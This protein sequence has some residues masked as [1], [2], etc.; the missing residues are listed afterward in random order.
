MQRRQLRARQAILGLDIDM[1]H[2]ERVDWQDLT[3]AFT[4][5][6]PDQRAAQ[7]RRALQREQI[8][9]DRELCGLRCEQRFTVQVRRIPR[10][11]GVAFLPI[12]HYIHLFQQR[13]EEY[14]SLLHVVAADIFPRLPPSAGSSRSSS[15]T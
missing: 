11:F 1:A 10:T 5:T 8:C 3:K 4:R 2:Q 14:C 6:R 15:Y 13:P 12:F 7:E 9:L